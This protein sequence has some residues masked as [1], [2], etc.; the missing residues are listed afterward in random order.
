MAI[1]ASRPGRRLRCRR[2]MCRL[3]PS[4]VSYY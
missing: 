4:H 3:T 1:A 2:L